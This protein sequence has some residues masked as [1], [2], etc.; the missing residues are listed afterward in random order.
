MALNIV[1]PAF[2]AASYYLAVVASYLAAVAAVASSSV[3][4]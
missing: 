2:A 3:A 4:A 1:L